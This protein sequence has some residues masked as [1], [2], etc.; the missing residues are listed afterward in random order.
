[1]FTGVKHTNFDEAMA[2][3]M[4]SYTPQSVIDAYYQDVLKQSLNPE[5]CAK[6][7]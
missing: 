5:L 2:S 3:G 7:V 1:M 6:A 4:I